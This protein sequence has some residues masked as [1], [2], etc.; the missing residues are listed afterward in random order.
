MAALIAERLAAP[1]EGQCVEHLVEEGVALLEVDAERCELG[2]LVAGPQAKD[3]SAARKLVHRCSRLGE[4]ERVP[5]GRDCEIGEQG[6]TRGEGT[7]VA[8]RH[9]RV[10]RLVPTAIEPPGAGDRV[11]GE[12]EP[13][14]ASRL[15]GAGNLGNRP[16]VKQVTVGAVRIGVLIEE[17]H[18][19]QLGWRS[20]IVRGSDG[21]WSA[22]G[23]HGSRGIAVASVTMPLPQVDQPVTPSAPPTPLG[24]RRCR[25]GAV[26]Q[27]PR[28]RP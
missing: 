27:P 12:R 9:E 2:L 15:G 1:V 6:D 11:L 24:W 10:Q 26:S 28:Q 7:S 17:A 13:C 25:A 21:G 22:H 4:Q 3:E 16:C 5:V 20:G 8:E 18:H 19:V 23:P 14:S